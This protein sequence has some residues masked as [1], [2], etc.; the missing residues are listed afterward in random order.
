VYG[1]KSEQPNVNIPGYHQTHGDKRFH[2]T[3]MNWESNTR[4]SYVKNE[5]THRPIE[6]KT[7]PSNFKMEETL[8][9]FK[10]TRDDWVPKPILRKSSMIPYVGLV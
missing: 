5:F 10:K 2:P 1:L 6:A 4:N 8:Y 7:I 3:K 9:G